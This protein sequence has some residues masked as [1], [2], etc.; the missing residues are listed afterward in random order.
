MRSFKIILL[1]LLVINLLTL[2]AYA[3][4]NDSLPS[5]PNTGSG[6]EIDLWNYSSKFEGIRLSIYFAPNKDG[7]SAQNRINTGE[8]VILIGKKVDITKTGLR[9]NVVG[10]TDYS[11]YDYMN[12]DKTYALTVTTDDTPYNYVIPKEKS[13]VNT[14]PKVFGGSKTEWDNWFESLVNGVKTY[15]NIPDIAD[16]V[17]ATISA[18][19]FKKGIYRY[20]NEEYTGIY[21][22]FF[23][24]IIYPV[25]NGVPTVMTLRDAIKWEEMFMAGEIT[26]TNGRRLTSNIPQ[27]FEYLA[28]SQFLIEDEACLS[29][30]A[31]NARYQVSFDGTQAAREEIRRQILPGG[32]IYDSMGVGVITSR[33]PQGDFDII[34]DNSIA[35][36][37][38]VKVTLSNDG[39][40]K[41]EDEVI[42]NHRFLNRSY[43]SRELTKIEYYIF[44]NEN[45]VPLDDITD[46]GR[47]VASVKS[48]TSTLTPIKVMVG[49]KTVIGMKMYFKDGVVFPSGEGNTYGDKYILHHVTLTSGEVEELIQ[50]EPGDSTALLRA[51]S[52]DNERFDIS[53]GIPS[54]EILYANVIADEY[55]YRFVP[56]KVT[57]DVEYTVTVEYTEDDE[58]SQD[59][60]EGGQSSEGTGPRTGQAV[61]HFNK[62]YSYW[63]VSSLEVYGIDGAEIING[64]L[65]GGKVALTP[66]G[67]NM[68]KVIFNDTPH[69]E[70]VVTG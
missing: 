43:T 59:G 1:W 19:D 32:H 52:R 44:D 5:D 18:E 33:A 56:N 55:I 14:L 38:T 31:N 7:K 35:T 20:E 25:V 66:N 47:L 64:A 37:K 16:L 6:K 13:Y 15:K 54:S 70:H 60:E 36:D 9:H 46:T 2:P 17:G 63:E 10:Y 22:I 26:D 4:N 29:M 57:G 11:V 58:D 61:F 41:V 68:P 34:Y 28:N 49:K 40:E 21:K 67:Y 24:P 30:R 23:E 12:G 27:I 3:G 53:Q 39:T 69:D 65:P 45:I 42:L 51:D 62:S 8:G 50:P 48:P